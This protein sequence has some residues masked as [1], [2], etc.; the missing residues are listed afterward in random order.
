MN[1]EL[2][3]SRLRWAGSKK[4]LVPKYRELM[5]DAPALY[6]EPFAGSAAILFATGPQ[7]AALGDI[8]EPLIDTYRWIR[9]D[10]EDVHEAYKSY[11]KGA[12][13]YYRARAEYNTCSPGPRRSGLFLYLNRLCFNGIY[14]TNKS[15]EFNVPYGGA[16]ASPPLA[17]AD[18]CAASRLLKKVKLR[19]QDFGRTIE[20]FCSPRAFFFIDPP[21]FTSGRRTFTE[22]SK[23]PFSENDLARLHHALKHIDRAGARFMVSYAKTPEAR[24]LA[25]KWNSRELR[26]HRQIGGF[27]DTRRYEI[28]MVITN[29]DT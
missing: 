26:V 22:Y 15:G 11:R 16:R 18:I 7:P 24:A 25:G 21:Y 9:S 12:A 29:Y 23:R 13:P 8:N 3:Q 17:L 10:P 2:V 5:P 14:R 27:A 28:E 19:K 6:V 20:E 4:K 1:R